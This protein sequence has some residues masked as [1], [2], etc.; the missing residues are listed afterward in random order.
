MGTNL[1]SGGVV[2]QIEKPSSP[3]NAK[4]LSVTK[5][6]KDVGAC[7]TTVVHEK[8]NHSTANVDV[9]Q[10][11]LVK[12]CKWPLVA[13]WGTKVSSQSQAPKAV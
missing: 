7:A 12:P 11:T 9:N 5:S 13:N 1:R 10:E 2:F 6:E 8:P 4:A 3:G